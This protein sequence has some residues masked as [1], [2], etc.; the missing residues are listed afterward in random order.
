[1]PK[2]PRDKDKTWDRPSVLSPGDDDDWHHEAAAVGLDHT[3]DPPYH[4]RKQ[5]YQFFQYVAEE[6]PN[7]SCR[8]ITE[9]INC[10]PHAT[11][12]Y[13][14]SRAKRKELIHAGFNFPTTGF[15]EESS[16]LRSLSVTKVPI[17]ARRTSSS[18]RSLRKIVRTKPRT[19]PWSYS[20]SNMSCQG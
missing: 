2:D 19:K 11:R 13:A 14:M 10:G 15:Y 4:T 5:T 17:C 16:K 8:F 1:M 7:V 12:T 6:L 9:I 20:Y 18:A 3:D